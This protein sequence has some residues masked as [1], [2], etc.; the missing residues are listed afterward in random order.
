[1]TGGG[2]T[3][4]Q[5]KGVDGVG[6]LSNV[7]QISAGG[8]HTCALLTNTNS[9]DCWGYNYSGQLGDDTTTQRSTPV[10]VK[11]V[12]GVGT[13][14]NV[15]QISAG[16]YHTCALLSGGTVDCWGDNGIGRLGNGTM[17][18]SSTPVS[19]KG[20][21]GTGTLS[22]VT[23]ISAGG[24]HTCALLSDNSVD[25]WGYNFFGQLGNGEMGHRTT[26]VSVIGVP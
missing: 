9:V 16:F 21:A 3:P 15:T 19:V 5:V 1:V 26:P 20:V 7:A 4:V 17:A 13:L 6:T 18:N 8:Y 24:Y 23:Q 2:S 10:P 11:G 14:S 22:N 25:C 12:G